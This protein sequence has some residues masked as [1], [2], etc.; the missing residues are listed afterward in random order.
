[1]TALNVNA[2]ELCAPMQGREHLA[3]I[4]LLGGIERAFDPL[5]LVEVYL[6]EHLAHEIAFLHAHTML[7][8]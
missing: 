6:G 1:M 2:S 7:T 5:L 3:G 4:K 8:G